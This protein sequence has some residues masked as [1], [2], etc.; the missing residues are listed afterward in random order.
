MRTPL[1]VIAILLAVLV[2]AAV[3]MPPDEEEGAAPAAPRTAPVDV[4]ARRVEALRDLRFE[5]LPEPERVSAAQ[6]RAE[7]LEELDRSYPVER[8]RADEE[9]LK[10][11]G[12]IEPDADLRELAASL[13]GEG[14]AGYYVP[15]SGR[16]RVVSGAATGTTVLAEMVLAHE[17]THA[18]EDQRYGLG[19]EELSGSDDATLARLA[20]IEGTAT[21]LM[22]AYASRHFTVEETLG[23]VLASAFADTGDLPPFLAAQTLFPYVQGEVFV[24]G[25]LRRARQS[26]SLV[27]TAYR[28][29]MPSSTEQI[30]H[31][32][33]YFDADEPADVRLRVARLLGDGWSRAA[34][35]TWGELQTRELL[36]GAGGGGSSD[37]AEGWGGDR[38]ELWRARPITGGECC[39]E[40]SVLVMR[41]RWDSRRD[42]SEFAAKLRQWAEAE[43]AG[44]SF[45]VVRRGGAV[46]LAVGPGAERVARAS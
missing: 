12:L 41:W 30:M 5:R 40:A 46:T 13:Y 19:L 44:R 23:G 11:L 6:A 24:S 1:T 32:D 14:V 31:P 38:Y 33:A 2:G 42:E 26:W 39:E 22:Y 25:L 28:F 4:I 27:D 9:I 43:L 7:G 8:R 34:A 37:A 3:A 15:R 29:R 18:L 16:L 36:A 35:G 45:A 20:M 10:L 21:A 17:L